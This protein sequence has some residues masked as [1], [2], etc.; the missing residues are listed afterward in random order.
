M[1]DSSAFL[2]AEEWVRSEGLHD[3]FPNVS[4]RKRKLVVG[5]KRDGSWAMHEFDA[6]SEDGAIVVSIKCSAGRT[7][8][9]RTPV[10]QLRAA[11]VDAWFLS[12]APGKRKI[13]VFTE[14][15]LSD[16]FRSVSDGKL[17]ENVELTHIPLPEAID[18]QVEAARGLARVEQGWPAADRQRPRHS[19]IQAADS[20]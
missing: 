15:D 9:G 3:L 8:G 17:P 4:F 1:A 13:I 10:G 5:T 18:R 7:S 12:R 2:V 20:H 11:Y 19:W 6:V 14:R 16:E